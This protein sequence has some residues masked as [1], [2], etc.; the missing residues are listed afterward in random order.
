[1]ASGGVGI[2]G[3]TFDPP[4]IGHLSIA[5][6]AYRRLGLEKV[7][8]IPA[9]VPWHRSGA[10]VAS[11]GHR[12]DMV[13]AAAGLDVADY[14]EVDDRE[15]LRPG[16][17]YTIDTLL[18][19]GDPNPCLI[20]GAD[21]ALGIPAWHRAEEVME[22]ARIAVAPRCGTEKEE[23]DAA[24][25]GRAEWLDMPPLPFSGSEIRAQA[26]RGENIESLVPV[27]VWHYI[28]MNG[29]YGYPE[30]TLVWVVRDPSAEEEVNNHPA[31]R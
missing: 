24:L 9:G 8:L 1:M 28:A 14:M 19:R 29:L 2:L 23:V 7:A 30:D 13:R 11:A 6:I 27:P 18:E 3:G 16:P 5:D 17:T 21:A 31:R 22:L 12:L 25:G 4:H 26:L 20:V 10:P 15:V